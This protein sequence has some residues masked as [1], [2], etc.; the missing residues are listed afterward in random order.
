MCRPCS[1]RSRRLR[2]TVAMGAALIV[3]ILVAAG[4][5]GDA[6]T[7]S[8][9]AA[10]EQTARRPVAV[11]VREIAAVPDEAEAAWIAADA[12]V[13]VIAEVGWASA[14]HEHA[15]I[16]LHG[17]DGRVLRA[18]ELDFAASEPKRERGKAVGFAIATM[19][20][21]EPVAQGILTS[22]AAADGASMREPA[23][24]AEPPSAEP[25]GS[26]T[27]PSTTTT[28]TTGAAERGQADRAVHD[29]PHPRFAVEGAGTAAGDVRG[30]SS[31]IG[32]VL[33]L[34]WN[35]GRD[36]G[37][38]VGGAARWFATGGRSAS[39]LAATAG[40]LW[41]FARSSSFA[42]AARAE[43]GALHDAYTE[44]IRETNP[45]GK[46]LPSRVVDT[47]TW[48]PSFL[49]G[50]EGDW[51]PSRMAALF[52]ALNA[53]ATTRSVTTATGG[54]SPIWASFE[55]GVRFSF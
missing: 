7:K 44:E 1:P 24:A 43:L 3:V 54:P 47:S 27:R 6:S 51:L 19:L 17:R 8:T 11:S 42:A 28:T 50:V 53:E 35:A 29:E 45:R 9:S 12:K 32:P 46:I 18:S 5:S 41:T 22:A 20:A 37:L 33:R 21:D 14:A 10:L 30:A 34:Q 16:H 25:D 55:G 40:V 52:L 2:S 4:E 38:R 48:A 26:R 49:A 39:E 15:T 36:L 31:G 13:D 23:S